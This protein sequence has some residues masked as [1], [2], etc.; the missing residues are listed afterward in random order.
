MHP[1]EARLTEAYA[2][3]LLL[4]RHRDLLAAAER[5]RSV[6]RRQRGQATLAARRR[7]ASFLASWAKRLDPELGRSENAPRWTS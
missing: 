4:D 6:P 3:R 2:A 1:N 5:R 7:L